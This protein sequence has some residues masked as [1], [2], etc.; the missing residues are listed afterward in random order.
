[1]YYITVCIDLLVL[2]CQGHT[3]LHKFDSSHSA[4]HIAN[5]L[6]RFPVKPK[7][8]IRYVHYSKDMLNWIDLIREVF[9]ALTWRNDERYHAPMCVSPGGNVFVKDY[10]EFM[11]TG[12]KVTGR[13]HDFICFE[14]KMG[15]FVTIEAL[16]QYPNQCGSWIISGMQC[17][18][19][20]AILCVLPQAGTRA[21]HIYKPDQIVGT[22]SL[23]QLNDDVSICV[24]LCV[25]VK[26][27]CCCVHFGYICVFR[28]VIFK[29]K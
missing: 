17:I 25:C 2:H 1:M 16:E 7:G 15:V 27:V 24:C 14:E 8:C 4:P 29:I 20:N 23:T 13:V 9:H 3:I 21:E 10:V 5:I 28:H 18:P 11:V 19:V 6:S 12:K 22:T 26:C